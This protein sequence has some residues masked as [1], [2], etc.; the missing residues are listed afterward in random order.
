MGNS[1]RLKLLGGEIEFDFYGNDQVLI[2]REDIIEEALRLQKIFNLY[3]KNSELSR[4]NQRGNLIV[5]E[6][7][8]YVLEDALH[9]CRISG[10]E[11]D[12]SKA[13]NFLEQKRGDKLSKLECSYKDIVLEGNLVKL[14]KGSKIDLGSIAKGYI[15]DKLKEFMQEL[16]IESAAID[17]RG[18][19]IIF[20]DTEEKI[21]IQHPRDTD[22]IIGS[23]T[24]NNQSI[25]TSGDY[26]QFH[27]SYDNSH[28]LNSKELI[29][30]TVIAGK[31]MTAD[32]LASAIFVS[33]EVYRD[34][35]I[36]RLPK[37]IKVLTVN[38]AVQIKKYNW[39]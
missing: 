4:L 39:D 19:I 31:L 13:T 36:S 8:R 9:H 11:Y 18:D 27:G 17:L 37:D 2:Y 28:I 29:S 20:G 34:G 12:I 32:V 5:S 30:V 6:D 3:D 21:S 35:I 1:F 25:A 10:G 22:Q 16:G 33:D 26:R 24:L 38:K 7:L 14:Q 23:V 15:G